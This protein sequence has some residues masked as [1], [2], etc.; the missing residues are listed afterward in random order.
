MKKAFL[1]TVLLSF[2][3]AFLT[4]GEYVVSTEHFDFIY[5]EETEESAAEIMDTA[6]ECYS[7]LVSFFG[8]DPSLHIPVYFESG[9]TRYNAHY[10]S[11]S[12][13]HIVM[14]VTAV[15]PELFANTTHSFQLTFYHEL[16]HAFTSSISN[17]FFSFLRSLFGDWI[18]PGNL[19]LDKSFIEG[20][21]V[22]M[23]SSEGEGRLNDPYTMTLM[24]EIS[25]E[26]FPFSSHSDI[27]GGLDISPSGN[28]S[29]IAGASFLQYLSD[30]Y[31]SESVSSFI[32]TCYLFPIS[33]TNGIFKKSFGISIKDAWNGFAASLT[34]ASSPEESENISGWGSWN[35]L[36]LDGGSL[37]V[38]DTNTASLYLYEKDGSGKKRIAFSYSSPDDLSFSP[39]FI[40]S[41]YVGEKKRSVNILRRNGTKYISFDDYYTGLL[42]S[43]EGVLLVT[44][45]D[46]NTTL[47]YRSLSDK[48]LIS[49]WS[50]GRDI[51]LSE[52]VAISPSLALFILTQNGMTRLLSVDTESGELSVITLGG[53]TYIHSLSLN[54]DG[55]LAFSCIGK[56]GSFTRYGEYDYENGTY[57]LSR[58]DFTGGVGCPVKDSDGTVYYVSEYIWS[59]R[60]SRRDISSFS[61]GEEESVT[62]SSFI[63]VVT[64]QEKKISGAEKYNVL[65]YMKKGMIMPLSGTRGL[66]IP[67]VSGLGVT[68]TA[69]D[70]SERHTVMAGA[71]YSFEKKTPM[72]MLFYSYSDFFSTSFSAYSE[73]GSAFFD[74]DVKGTYTF[75]LGS[76][77]RS[78]TLSDTVALFSLPEMRGIANRFS[79]TY[80]DLY[81]MGTG[82]Y[83]V[84]G[85]GAEAVLENLSPS[86]VLSLYLPRI[87]PVDNT[88]RLGFNL[89]FRLSLGVTD[90]VK[91]PV[92]SFR[93]K[94]YLFTWEIQKSLPWLGI[95]LQHLDL[96]FTYDGSLRMRGW[97]YRDSYALGAKLSLTPLVGYLSSV[98]I[99][100]NGSVT[101][102]VTDGFRFTWSFGLG[103]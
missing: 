100:L 48:S 82:R 23:E 19:Y 99:S 16:T 101:Y 80:C 37:Y 25:A 1:L 69:T 40:L 83:C 24:S 90:A 45:S 8:T 13:S 52:G 27:A 7:K 51:T 9:V 29:Y 103:E 95:Y 3:L 42:L 30:T 66:Y 77:N 12:S 56:N 2:S 28:L 35:N 79:V 33:T 75:D 4:A 62:V 17:G 34:T 5:S 26:G 18:T 14:Y 60:I 44:E 32:R 94:L 93:G 74:F 47:E 50:L 92:F 85:W 98:A 87:I 63:P 65:E 53:D 39:S 43:D 46:R 88:I 54:A 67:D 31:G 59:S 102:T 71:G 97:E 70:P 73:S 84:L 86:F 22:Y 36:T 81:P 76:Y 55:T 78:L 96:T 64:P 21:A 49:S 57:M 68:M 61:F 58:N 91:N 72:M 6:E 11:Y 10:S 15:T 89:P 38:K 41:P 20:I